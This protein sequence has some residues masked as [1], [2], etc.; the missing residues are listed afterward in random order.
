VR[1]QF[2]LWLNQFAHGFTVIIKIFYVWWPLPLL[3]YIYILM[4]CTCI[5]YMHSVYISLVLYNALLSDHFNIVFVLYSQKSFILFNFFLT[6][7][8]LAHDYLQLILQKSYLSKIIELYKMLKYK[9][10]EFIYI[11]IYIY[12]Y[13]YIHIYII[14]IF[15]GIHNKEGESPKK[16]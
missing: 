14:Y 3:Q 1:S 8:K 2:W 6:S 13:M 7:L 15:S 11:Y 16:N 5:M 4:Y 9:T 12:T 10:R